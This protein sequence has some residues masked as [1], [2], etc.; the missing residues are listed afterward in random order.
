MLQFLPP[1]FAGRTSRRFIRIAHTA[2]FG[3][4]GGTARLAVSQMSERHRAA[5][6]RT[7]EGTLAQGLLCLIQAPLGKRVVRRVRHIGTE[8][9]RLRMASDVAVPRFTARDPP[10]PSLSPRQPL[11]HRHL[12]HKTAG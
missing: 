1:E 11:D 5:T 3:R 4:S 7:V 10:T 12:M 8:L 2:C 6:C 9:Y